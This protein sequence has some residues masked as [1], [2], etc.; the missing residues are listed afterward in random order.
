MVGVTG[1]NGKTT[2]SH[3]IEYFLLQARRDTAMLGTLYT[4]WKGYSQTATH[5]TPFCCRVAVSASR[6]GKGGKRVCGNGS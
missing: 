2:T 1:T 4:R 3:L 6:S 5:T